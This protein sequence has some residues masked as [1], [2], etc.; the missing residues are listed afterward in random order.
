[1]FP[2]AA[3]TRAPSRLAL[4]NLA[5]AANKSPY[6]TVP[7]NIAI[8][9][10]KTSKNSMAMSAPFRGCGFAKL[11][12]RLRMNLFPLRP[13]RAWLTGGKAV[14]TDPVKPRSR[15]NTNNMIRAVANAK[16]NEYVG[17]RREP[18]RPLCTAF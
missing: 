9:N 8:I 18:R 11:E 5:S 6:S 15:D 2:P 3:A 10:G 4:N 7:K 16:G 1:M 17:P 14:S 13:Q 12:F